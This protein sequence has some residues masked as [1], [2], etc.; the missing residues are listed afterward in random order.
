MENFKNNRQKNIVTLLK[1]ILSIALVFISN[2]GLQLSQNDLSFSLAYKFTF[3][4]HTEKFML[5]CLVLGL[6]LILC[7]SLLGSVWI[8][9]LVYGVII[10][11]V[12]V[13]NYLKMFYRS[14]PLYPED[15][16]MASEVKL[17]SEM[18][19]WPLIILGIILVSG[20]FVLILW[21]VYRSR[22]LPIKIQAIRGIVL[23]LSILSLTYVSQFNHPNNLLRKAYD[24]TAKWIPYSQKMNY[25]NTGFIGGFLFNLGIEPMPE[26]I[27]YS[28]D[29]INEIVA[30]YEKENTLNNQRKTTMAE[31]PNIVYIMS[32]SFSDPSR[33]EGIHI[34]EDPLLTY[35]QLAADTYSGRVLSQNYGGGTANIEFEALTGLSMEPFN[36]QMTTPYTMLVPKLTELPSIVSLLSNQGYD[37]TAIHPYNTSMYKRQDVYRK[38][39]FARFLSEETMKHQEK[40]MN[41]QYISDESAFTE[42]LDILSENKKEQFVHLVTMQTHMPYREK[43]DITEPLVTGV[44]NPLSISSYLT[45]VGYTSEALANFLNQLKALDRR[46]VVVFWG[47]HLPSIYG[48]DIK[49]KNSEF[50][51]HQTEFAF[52]DTQDQFEK[53]SENN[54][55]SP[56]YF[57]PKLFEKSHLPQSG[58]YHLLNQLSEKIPAFEKQMYYQNGSWKPTMTVTPE[59]EKVYQD[60]L[61]IQFDLVGG[62]QYS[63]DTDFYQAAD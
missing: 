25:Y 42:V 62:K 18:V 49:G 63:V 20:V 52:F 24:H 9:T 54:V 31:R 12:G 41:N 40:I 23:C 6:L 33:L 32:E 4:W 50:T 3:E 43:Y 36:G 15:L 2:Y 5:G 13:A 7:Q 26:P 34:P 59:L 44:T 39:G 1:G 30:N 47:D 55:L 22:R 29:K 27:D 46:T 57:G 45:D 21:Q 14:E 53:T 17:L 16:K 61:N 8:G 51:L 10:M 35:R 60:Y 58:F 48:D 37:T 38:L 28:K 19:G 56:I 11:L